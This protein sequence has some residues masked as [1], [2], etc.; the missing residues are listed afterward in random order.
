MVGDNKILTVSYGTF[1]CTLEGFDDPFSMMKGITEYFRELAERDRFFGAEP[2]QPDPNAL[3]KIAERSSNTSV[4]V[5]VKDNMTVLRNASHGGGS[6]PVT[7]PPAA[8]AVAAALAP[9]VAEGAASSVAY[10]APPTPTAPPTLSTVGGTAYGS[11]DTIAEKLQRIRA[12]VARDV[13]DPDEVASFF[14]E[15]QHADIL[16]AEPVQVT[17]PATQPAPAS[18]PLAQPAPQNAPEPTAKPVVDRSDASPTTSPTSPQ[19]T[20]DTTQGATAADV[21]S[22]IDAA[23]AAVT[24]TPDKAEA[25]PALSDPISYEEDLEEYGQKDATADL[26]APST[27]PVANAGTASPAPKKVTVTSKPAHAINTDQADAQKQSSVAPSPEKDPAPEPEA[28]VGAAP[29]AEEQVEKRR[30]RPISRMRSKIL[31]NDPQLQAQ[32]AEEDDALADISAQQASVTEALSAAALNGEDPDLKRSVTRPVGDADIGSDEAETGRVKSRRRIKVQKIS[33]EDVEAA[34]PSSEPFVSDGTGGLSPEAE[35]A[36]MEELE[37][38]EAEIDNAVERPKTKTLLRTEPLEEF[39]LARD[40]DSSQVKTEVYH[41]PDLDDDDDFEDDGRGLKIE[42]GLIPA[43]RVEMSEAAKA[44]AASG[45]PARRAIVT[46]KLRPGET[47]EQRAARLERRVA[48][49]EDE[50]AALNRL[51]DATSSRMSNDEEGVVRR[52]SIAHLKA[53]VAAT[54]ADESITEAYSDIEERELDQYRTDL[55]KVVRPT[56]SKPLVRKVQTEAESSQPLML[57]S[58]Q[59]VDADTL[60]A[61]EAGS[62]QRLTSGNLALQPDDS[63]GAAEH[64]FGAFAAQ[65]DALDL[66]DLLEA[67]AAHFTFV[68]GIE[69]FSRPMLMRKISSLPSSESISREAGLRSF[70]ALLREGTLV[71]GEDGKFVLSGSSRFTPEAREEG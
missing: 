39:Q 18:Q 65:Y 12:V 10:A 23:A 5:A 57:V 41:E 66:P 52:A 17:Q 40:E 48:M 6:Q 1:S 56:K 30:S 29:P 54:K 67:A 64:D 16:D 49:L 20:Q 35:A 61:E 55:A 58:K 15:D 8:T 43:P 47:E 21:K 46:S 34:Q 9:A 13:A 59:R 31:R 36:L 4:D 38:V 70:G 45:N 51:M 62:D 26:E 28:E 71:K 68:E 2:P 24:P 32:A 42:G 60:A 44:A 33:R 69:T 53:A 22:D 14:S 37:A 27:P 50:D 3:L 7:A 19:D 63:I 25:T 11:G